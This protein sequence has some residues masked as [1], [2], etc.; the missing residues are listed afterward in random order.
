[1]TPV[2]AAALSGLAKT[3]TPMS[4]SAQSAPRRVI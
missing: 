2:A 3:P 4:E 1:L